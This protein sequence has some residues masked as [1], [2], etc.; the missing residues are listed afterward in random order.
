MLAAWLAVGLA[1]AIEPPA[2]R[3]AALPLAL[4]A[5]LPH[6]T[7]VGQLGN[8]DLFITDHRTPA[9]LRLDPKT[10]RTTP[11]GSAGAGSLQYV[12]PAGVFA[13]ANDTL[14]IVDR[15]LARVLVVNAAGDIIS[16]SSIAERG[17]TSS[18]DGDFEMRQVDAAGHVYYA[19]PSAPG[20]ST[21]ALDL[22][23]L[24]PSS[25]RTL[26][27]ASLA[28]PVTRS[29]SGGPNVTFS[30]AVVGSPADGWG[31]EP[32]GRVAVVRAS[33]YRV[34]WFG[35]DGRA[36]RGPVIAHDALPMTEADRQAHLDSTQPGPSVGLA[37]GARSANPLPPE[38]ATTKPPFDRADVFVSSSGEVWVKRTAAFGATTAIY[39]VFDRTGLRSDRVEVAQGR[40]VGAGRT[41][42]FI[43]VNDPRGGVSLLAYRR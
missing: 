13:G 24:E 26:T 1:A 31:V 42:I 14:L 4:A 7:G 29:V 27:L 40:L 17:V 21:A 9:V 41:T 37:G 16:S 6:V 8:G 30:R 34:E 3:L 11:V 2:R 18:S 5:P 28:L 32:G 36:V 19:T 25:Q 10:G 33:P 39:D 38:F 35:S 22:V 23:R 43:R 20:H 12:K 15:G